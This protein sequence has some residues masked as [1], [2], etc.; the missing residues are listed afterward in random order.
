M[1]NDET[2]RL[3]AFVQRSHAERDIAGAN[4]AE[5]A[6]IQH[7][8]GLIR[9]LARQAATGPGLSGEASDFE[10][11]ASIAFLRAVRT[12]DL[13]IP[14]RLSTYATRLIR[15]HLASL[16]TH[17]P[18]QLCEQIPEA[19]TDPYAAD[20]I[21][22]D[23]PVNYLDCLTTLERRVVELRWGLLDGIERPTAEV[24][25]MLLIPVAVATRTLETATRK[26]AR[27]PPANLSQREAA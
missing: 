14:V 21:S 4:E 16:R 23:L 12:F 7:N 26:L 10:Q 18:I 1:S 15:R 19:R 11:E 8:L 27:R 22:P 2:R 3:I 24:A 6:L 5:T 25:E 9:G 13:A 17:Q 20:S